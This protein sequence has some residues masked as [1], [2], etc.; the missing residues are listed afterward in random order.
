MYADIVRGYD[1][2][3]S[4]VNSAGFEAALVKMEQEGCRPGGAKIVPKS[5]ID[6]WDGYLSYLEQNKKSENK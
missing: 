5:T 4:I 3:K 1:A 6:Y 2:A